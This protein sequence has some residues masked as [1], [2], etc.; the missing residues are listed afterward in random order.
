MREVYL[1]SASPS[2]F[3]GA[4]ISL[5]VAFVLIMQAQLSF[6]SR[7][8]WAGIILLA[9][10]GFLANALFTMIR[11]RVLAWHIDMTRTQAK[12]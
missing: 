2:I 11:S 5:Q 10:L 4:Q 3:G 6:D 1:P 7:T 9:L 8:M 12:G